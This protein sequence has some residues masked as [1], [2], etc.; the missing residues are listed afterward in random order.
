[1]AVSIQTLTGQDSPNSGRLK[2]NTNFQSL[3]TIVDGHITY[4]TA[5]SGDVVSTDASQTIINKIITSNNATSGAGNAITIARQDFYGD[6]FGVQNTYSGI[7]YSDAKIHQINKTNN[8]ITI[9]GF[10]GIEPTNDITNRAIG[11]GFPATAYL[12]HPDGNQSLVINNRTRLGGATLDVGGLATIRSAVEIGDASDGSVDGNTLFHINDGLDG[13]ARYTFVDIESR[14]GIADAEGSY[15]NLKRNPNQAAT[16]EGQ[17]LG[18]ITFTGNFGVG[19]TSYDDPRTATR[20]TGTALKTYAS[21]DRQSSLDFWLDQGGSAVATQVMRI[22]GGND[23]EGGAGVIIGRDSTDTGQLH[24][25]PLTVVNNYTGS[26]SDLYNYADTLTLADNGYPGLTMLAKTSN[27]THSAIAYAKD[28]VKQAAIRYTFTNGRFYFDGTTENGALTIDTV[29]DRVGFGKV[30]A[31]QSPS[32]DLQ[33]HGTSGT[34]KTA[35]FDVLRLNPDG[36]LDAGSDPASCFA[37]YTDSNTNHWIRTKSEN[38]QFAITS[39]PSDWK[40][41]ILLYRTGGDSGHYMTFNRDTIISN[42]G[43][44]N[45][46]IKTELKLQ[47]RRLSSGSYVG[48]LASTVV[49][50]ANIALSGTE[51]AS[52]FQPLTLSYFDKPLIRLSDEGVHIG[53]TSDNKHVHPG[54]HHGNGSDSGL[55]TGINMYGSQLWSLGTDSTYTST[56]STDLGDVAIVWH[57]KQDVY[58]GGVGNDSRHLTITDG[59]SDNNA[60]DGGLIID[61]GSHKSGWGTTQRAIA[62]FRAVSVSQPQAMFGLRHEELQG[63]S[64]TFLGQMGLPGKYTVGIDK[65]SNNRALA[66]NGDTYINGQLRLNSI[67]RSTSIMLDDVGIASGMLNIAPSS[68][69]VKG[70]AIGVY[71]PS[72]ISTAGY[73]CIAHLEQLGGT[74]AKRAFGLGM[75]RSG[76][77]AVA[78]DILFGALDT[79]YQG[80]FADK[81]DLKVNFNM[82]AAINLPKGTTA[83]RPGG[84]A[85]DYP[86]EMGDMRYNTDTNSV[87]YRNNSAWVNVNTPPINATYIQYGGS[88]QGTYKPENLYP[89]TTWTEGDIPNDCFI[90]ARGLDT[91]GQSYRGAMPYMQVQMD[92]MGQHTHRNTAFVSPRPWSGDAFGRYSEGGSWGTSTSG[93]NG[94]SHYSG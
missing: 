87:E 42:N 49:A 45:S 32:Y 52:V 37:L 50:E 12:D 82:T 68:N 78:G 51:D 10:G 93:W 11:I 2:I 75:N 18:A 38:D 22:M 83:Q 92:M 73:N 65:A 70:S 19:T 85:S 8:T 47:T 9:S 31:N 89:G 81:F 80:S 79:Y 15:I 60:C 44:T 59:N 90:R 20:I 48:R 64:V 26:Y 13:N 61:T 34:P 86:A 84:T 14:G 94:N 1:M 71:D 54:R 6:W 43:G 5:L 30:S 16:I 53:R 66:V 24:R 25:A 4:L 67:L 17:N 36:H 7:S 69:P 3:K 77:S 72:H 74:G 88:N 28:D 55:K 56:G 39:D 23:S 29:N 40:K 76:S 27:A 63:G 41:S 33:A 21:G 58:A 35:S 62:S 91:E 46:E 57:S